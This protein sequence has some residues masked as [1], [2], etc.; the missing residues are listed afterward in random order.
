MHTSEAAFL[1]SK[2][3]QARRLPY[4][5]MS[6]ASTN[7]CDTTRNPNRNSSRTIRRNFRAARVFRSRGRK[8]IPAARFARRRFVRSEASLDDVQTSPLGSK[9]TPDGIDYVLHILISKLRRKRDRSG[10]C[11]DPFGVWQIA[12]F[13][14][15]EF[16]IEGL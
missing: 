11:A 2:C 12:F 14:A 7:I 16:A 3:R 9:N 8:P 5:S 1:P 13:V 4:T 10:S 15:E 6:S